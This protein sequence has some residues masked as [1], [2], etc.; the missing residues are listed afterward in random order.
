MAKLIQNS[1][2]SQAFIKLFYW[3]AISRYFRNIYLEVC[4]LKAHVYV[5]SSLVSK[6]PLEEQQ[7][8]L[9]LP[10]IDFRHLKLHMNF[11]KL[12]PL[13]TLDFD[14]YLPKKNAPVAM[15]FSLHLFRVLEIEEPP[16]S[17]LDGCCCSPLPTGKWCS[18]L[19]CIFMYWIH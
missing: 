5:M 17:K 14:Y 9:L 11:K 4:I 13:E 7:N 6:F 2:P 1:C 19:S 12:W 15:E 10:K 3:V 18:L 8:T 16:F